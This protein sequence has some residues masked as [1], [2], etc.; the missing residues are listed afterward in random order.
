M[1]AAGS[2]ERGSD[3]PLPPLVGQ[4]LAR[5]ED[6]RLLTGRGRYIADIVRDGMLHAAVLRSPRPHGRIRRIDIAKAA[7]LP[8]VVGVSRPPILPVA[9]KPI[10]P[11]I[12][13]LPGFENFLQFADRDR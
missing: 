5:R 10:R 8:G 13:A 7:A 6:A 1:R 12:G 9:W 3:G 11:R 2:V 4:P